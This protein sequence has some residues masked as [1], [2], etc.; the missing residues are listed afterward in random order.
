MAGKASGSEALRLA[1]VGTLADSHLVDALR[2]FESQF[3]DVCVE[4]RTATSREVS[5][6]VRSG[7]AALGLRYFAD[8][9]PKLRNRST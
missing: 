8:A 9:D 5:G 6:L 7:E 2:Q 1:I 4:L 3:K